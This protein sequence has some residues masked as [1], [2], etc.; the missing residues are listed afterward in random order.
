MS[1]PL[2]GNHVEDVAPLSLTE[3]ALKGDATSTNFLTVTGANLL[4]RD[5]GYT[6]GAYEF[7]G[8][9]DIGTPRLG[10]QTGDKVKLLTAGSN[11]GEFTVD[12]P[13]TNTITVFETLSTPDA[14]QYEFELIR[15]RA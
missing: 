9:A 1:L 6:G 2:V 4:T 5:A 15:R 13:G 11:Q 10:L 7:Q 3:V 14:T 8:P 12:T